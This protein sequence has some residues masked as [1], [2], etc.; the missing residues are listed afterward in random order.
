MLS[1]DII[2]TKFKLKCPYCRCS[3]RYLSEGDTLSKGDS[4]VVV[5]SDK[6][7]MDVETFYDGILVSV[8]VDEGEVRGSLCL[9]FECAGL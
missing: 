8:L 9:H 7:D 6:A 4:V 5:E 3:S 1:A 2:I